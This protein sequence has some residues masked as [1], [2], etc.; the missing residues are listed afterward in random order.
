MT[1]EQEGKG[2]CE[3]GVIPGREQEVQGAWG[4]W[5]VLETVLNNHSLRMWRQISMELQPPRY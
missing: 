4:T 3:E 2:K 1:D 5:N